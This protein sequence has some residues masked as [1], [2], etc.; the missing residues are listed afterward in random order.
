MHF[1][2][3]IDRTSDAE[4]V[5]NLRTI[6]AKSLRPGRHFMANFKK[7]HKVV[8]LRKVLA[9]FLD[10]HKSRLLCVCHKARIKLLRKQKSNRIKVETFKVI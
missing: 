3:F 6:K 10:R 1:R 7:T 2:E 4:V 8:V 9:K 5:E